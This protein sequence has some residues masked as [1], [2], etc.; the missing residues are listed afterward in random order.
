MLAK[1]L[2]SR[3][4]VLALL[5]AVVLA[6]C[7]PKHNASDA[8][9]DGGTEAGGGSG[10]KGGEGKGKGGDAANRPVPVVTATVEKKDVPIYLEGLGNVVAYYTVT[11]TPLVDG[12]VDKVL[13]RE[14]QVVHKGDLLAQIDPRPYQV[15][16]HQAE[17]ALVRDQAQLKAAKLDLERYR[18][19]ANKKL[20]AQQQA[21]DQTGVVGQADGAVRVDQA[22][23]ESAK[24]N[25]EYASIT[26]PIDGVTGIRLVDPGNVV[27]AAAATQIV[28]LT[29]LNP[30][31]VLFTLPEDVLPQVA[32]EMLAGTLPVEAWS[33]DG[34]TK[35]GTGETLLINNQINQ[36]TGT[37][38][39]KA[40]FQNPNHALWP[41]QFVK[42]RLLL[43]TR[44][45]AIAVP[46]AG[47]AARTEGH[48]RVHR[49]R[50]GPDGEDADHRG[51]DDRR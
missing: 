36:A 32:K 42:A 50:L 41:N 14:G 34:T 2:L 25:L 10:K 27:H 29:Q 51:R 26:A 9:T 3:A 43:T 13:F 6:G 40:I 47:R 19:L 46:R 48:L 18:D 23:I 33:R 39:M 11:I 44:K 45:G 20:I 22:Q 7:T 1:H 37:L 12:R 5:P 21:D 35:L 49:R 8:A 30:I 15:Q 28:V 4:V 31:A 38:Q 24:L 17:G 16:L